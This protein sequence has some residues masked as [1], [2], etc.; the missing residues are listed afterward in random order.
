ME[1]AEVPVSAEA[2]ARLVK[3]FPA[4]RVSELVRDS[5]PMAPKSNSFAC[6]VVAV[7]PDDGAALLPVAVATRSRYE[8]EIKPLTENAVTALDAAEG[9][10][11]VIVLPETNA[12][13]T[14]A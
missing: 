13:F 7:A 1:E 2:L 5:L 14:D 11:T 12:L 10:V 8:A 3:L 4:V 9:N 6:D